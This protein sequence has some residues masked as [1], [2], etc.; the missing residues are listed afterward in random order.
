MGDTKAFDAFF[1]LS[2]VQ[3]TGSGTGSVFLVLV[4][5]APHTIPGT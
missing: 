1:A 3:A 5:S 4:S 2:V